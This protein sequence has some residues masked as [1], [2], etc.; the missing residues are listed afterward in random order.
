MD[1]SQEDAAAL[2]AATRVL[3]KESL[4]DF[5]YDVRSHEAL[6]WEGPRV[7]AWSNACVVLER[8]AAKYPAAE[9]GGGTSTPTSPSPIDSPGRS[10]V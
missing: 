4:G 1:I 2:L 9:A 5:I 6:G 10:E 3:L 8:V 7:V